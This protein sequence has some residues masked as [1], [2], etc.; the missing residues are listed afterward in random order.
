MNCS[1]C[2]DIS[3]VCENHPDQPWEGPHSCSALGLRA[4]PP[5]LRMQTVAILKRVMCASSEE[6]AEPG[7]FQDCFV[8]RT[9]RLRS[10]ESEAAGLGLAVRF[11][12]G[13]ALERAKAL[14]RAAQTAWSEVSIDPDQLRRR[15]CNSFPQWT[16]TRCITGSG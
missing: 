4:D 7:L 9:E 5:A 11:D 3:W 14:A 16:E 8:L 6:K 10:R 1:R 2:D 12:R 13:T 15:R